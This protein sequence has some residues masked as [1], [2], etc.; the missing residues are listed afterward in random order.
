MLQPRVEGASRSLKMIDTPRESRS[1]ML[2]SWPEGI[3]GGV[4]VV[5]AR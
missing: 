2:E 4:K 5:R 1:G 3:K